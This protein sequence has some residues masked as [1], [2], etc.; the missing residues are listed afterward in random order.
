MKVTIDYAGN[1]TLEGDVADLHQIY[2]SMDN[3]LSVLCFGERWQQNETARTQWRPRVQEI[4]E[5]INDA[6]N[7]F[8][9]KVTQTPENEDEG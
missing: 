5:K 3:W 8:E 9:K 7:A 6:L 4:T 1:F 2:I